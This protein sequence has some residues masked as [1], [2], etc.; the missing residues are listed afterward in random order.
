LTRQDLP[1]LQF[2][3]AWCLN[4][5]ASGENEH[6]QVLLENGS[7]EAFIKLFASPYS[8]V[9]EQA[10]WGLGNLAGEN[11]MV[12]DVVIAAGVVEPIANLLD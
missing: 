4:N 9:I 11:P 8:E 12:R 7:V 3:A 10:I 6:V 5:V 1:K 2:E